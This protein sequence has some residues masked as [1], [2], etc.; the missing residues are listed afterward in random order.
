MYVCIVIIM[1]QSRITLEEYF[2]SVQHED[3]VGEDVSL[4]D[5]DMIL[6][7]EEEEVEHGGYF[8]SRVSIN[9]NPSLIN[10]PDNFKDDKEDKE[11]SYHEPATKKFMDIV[12]DIVKRKTSASEVVFSEATVPIETFAYHKL[13]GPESNG[14]V[15]G[16]GS[17][18]TSLNLMLNGDDVEENQR[19]NTPLV[20]EPKRGSLAATPT[21]A[22]NNEVYTNNGGQI[23]NTTILRGKRR[24]AHTS[25]SPHVLNFL[26]ARSN[27][28]SFSFRAI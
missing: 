4:N 7:L 5:I 24:A 20:G 3:A 18:V 2:K 22:K 26:I 8:R 10:I 16:V 28:L 1:F 9:M 19:N 15:R 25:R 23:E 17:G 27:C 13:M 21:L 14:R 11:G 6:D 12:V